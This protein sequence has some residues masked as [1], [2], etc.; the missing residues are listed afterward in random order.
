MSG[1]VGDE[2]AHQERARE[3]ARVPVAC[4]GRT[5]GRRR[6][7]LRPVRAAVARTLELHGRH[8]RSGITRRRGQAVDGAV[9]ER[10]VGRKGESSARKRVIDRHGHERRSENILRRIR[11]HRTNPIGAC[12]GAR[13]PVGAV[14]RA[15]TGRGGDR[16]VV[17]SAIAGCFE[18]H[19]RH[20][21]ADVA[22]RRRQRVG[23]TLQQRASRWS[24]KRAAR[25]GVVDLDQ[26]ARCRKRVTHGIGDD[27]M[28]EV[29]VRE[30]PGIP[31]GRVRRTRRTRGGNRGPVGVVG[32]ALEGHRHGRRVRGIST[33]RV[34]R[35]VKNGAGGRVHRSRR[36]CRVICHLNGI[37]IRYDYAVRCLDVVTSRA[38]TRRR[39]VDR[40]RRTRID[41]RQTDDL[42]VA[43]ARRAA[44]ADHVAGDE[45]GERL[46]VGIRPREMD[47]SRGGHDRRRAGSLE[48][49][50]G[51]RRG[52][53]KQRGSSHD[54]GC[55]KADA[56]IRGSR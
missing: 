3:N 36:I 27:C 30:E 8:A 5:R 53:S 29:L 50:R 52:R 40:V 43:G 24:G 33:E 41:E 19:R 7:D 15:R 34:G 13:V 42:R 28:N 51:K 14:R 1:S 37:G 21:G 12:E 35:S 46:G 49:R 23:R 45:A 9:Q 20:A 10:Q 4:V 32:G 39:V 2:R 31:V 55:K 48:N 25:Q 18:C 56:H 11:D 26:D 38:V 44:P 22:R 47:R 16:G 17:G 54:D 6:D